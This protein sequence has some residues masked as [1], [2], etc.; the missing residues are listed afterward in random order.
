MNRARNNTTPNMNNRGGNIND[1]IGNTNGQNGNYNNQN[2]NMN[3]R[4]DNMN[5]RNGNLNNQNDFYN[6]QNGNMNGRM[7]NMYTQNGNNMNGQNDRMND[8]RNIGGVNRGGSALR[9][10]LREQIKALSFV[11]VELELYLDT[12]PD[13]RTAIDYYLRTVEALKRLTEE[14]ENTEGPLTCAGVVN[15]DRWTWVDSPWPWQ[16]PGDYMQPREDR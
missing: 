9:G 7:G 5:N 16:R 15:S 1:R 10:D 4:G 13:C 12:H 14:Y 6:N 3:G 8:G 2:R 11:K